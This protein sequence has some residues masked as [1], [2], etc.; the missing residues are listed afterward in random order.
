MPMEED[1]L[2]QDLKEGAEEDAGGFD[3]EDMGEEVWKGKER[4][5][6]L[7]SYAGSSEDRWES[8]PQEGDASFMHQKSGHTRQH[9]SGGPNQHKLQANSPRAAKERQKQKK[10]R[11]E[12]HPDRIEDTPKALGEYGTGGG[13]G[14]AVPCPDTGNLVGAHDKPH[15]EQ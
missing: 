2:V 4:V 5:S 10:A 11:Q 13:H 14:G 8:Q 15:Q 3:Q 7:D 12:L 6:G 1:Q 9:R